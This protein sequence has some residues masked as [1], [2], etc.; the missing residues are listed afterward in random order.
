MEL[1]SNLMSALGISNRGVDIIGDLPVEVAE[2]ILQKLD[3]LSLMNAAKVSSKWMAICKGSSRLRKTA[4]RFLRRKKVCIIQD[5]VINIRCGK[6]ADSRVP[7]NKTR[8]NQIHF[9]YLV[10]QYPLKNLSGVYKN[11]PGVC[12]N[13]LKLNECTSKKL[14]KTR[15]C[16]RLR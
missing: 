14:N 8:K 10:P 12:D 11:Q 4:R 9:R 13:S 3:P 5:D 16:L 7:W 15:S 2:L 6:S 1:F